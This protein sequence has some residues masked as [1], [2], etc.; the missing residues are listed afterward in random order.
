VLVGRDAEFGALRDAVV[1]AMGGR[2]CAVC[3]EGEPGIGKTALVEA[4][5]AGI[6]QDHPAVQVVSAIGVESEFSLA[7]AGLL[8]LLTPMLDRLDAL[9]TGQRLALE[10]AFG[11]SESPEGADRFLVAVATL[12]LLSLHADERP[13]IL[14]LDDLQWIDPETTAALNFSARRIGH[15]RIAM[16]LT[17][18]TLPGTENERQ[19]GVRLIPLAG[20]PA[21]DAGELLAGTVAQILVE[22]LVRRTGGNPLALLELTRSLSPAQRRGSVPLPTAL[23]VG[24]RLSEAFA[25]S[26]AKLS[27]AARRLVTLTAA[28]IDAE[29]GPLLRAMDDEGI[30]RVSAVAQAESSGVLTFHT[31]GVR[32]RHPLL[33]NA[34][35]L[36][37]TE[38]ERRSAHSSLASAYQHRPGIRLRHLAE[39]STGPDDELGAAL[40]TLAD[41]E[42]TRSGFAAA[43]VIAERASVL[44]S[45]SGP[46][47]DALAGAVEDAALSGDVERV[48]TLVDRIGVEPVDVSPQA[49]AR[50]LLCAGTLEGNSGSVTRAAQLLTRAAEIGTGI[51]RVRSLVELLHAHY[52]LGSVEGMALAAAAIEVNADPGE[53]EQAM[54]VAYSAASA[55]A[56]AGDGPAAAGPAMRA[57][58]LLDRTPGLL[59]DPRHLIVAGLASSWAGTLQLAYGDAPRRLQTARS[60]GAIGVLPTVLTLLAG[61]ATVFGR[62]QDAFAYAG[63]AVELGTE[64]GFVVDVST[65]QEILAWELAA[66]DYPEQA[67]QALR[68][69]RLLHDRAGVSAA[70]VH[71]ELVEAF[72]A[73]CAGNL[74]RVV[75]ILEDR[76]AVDGGR[77][78]SGN[79]PMSVA[80]DLV[81]AYLGL[82]R[83]DDADDITAR[84]AELHRDS[85][86]PDIRGEVLRLAGMTT[87]NL[88][89]AMTFFEA[90]HLAHTAG[91]DTFSA[92]RTR[93]LHG[94][95][96]RRAGERRAA[97]EQLRLAAEAFRLMGLTLWVRR[98]EAE[99]AATGSTARRG[100][101]RD[102][103]L[104]S[105]ETRV[106]LFVAKGLTNREIAAALFLSPRTVEHHVTSVLRKRGLNSRV[107]LAAEFAS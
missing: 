66:R 40:L 35:W 25:Q 18:R 4:V 45:G 69:A 75:D 68:D 73:L 47:L 43:S 102:A 94:Q 82:H 71:V 53:P 46:S 57:V 48:R 52:R 60:Q 26:I 41:S 33:R 32:F 79:Y 70:A 20:L 65:A 5:V 29:T 21:R 15:D 92:A 11:R 49:H 10:R 24:G 74:Q 30:D 78:P 104:T 23:P 77:Q 22:P 81:E 8:D 83:P 62:H 38:T 12:A 14:L 72:C 56:F 61:G 37:A 3:V 13:L 34:A 54:L 16:L 101:Q 50:A 19:P 98:A 96:L 9:P 105:Q 31:D 80:P 6:R 106:A 100:P 2:G 55:L 103:A 91:Y 99:L 44:L 51:T 88:P 63:E 90:A 58:E 95:R 107:E 42:R 89:E 36:A 86:D 97:R 39:A 7:H 85:P 1:G 17:R 93:L 84:H 27:P 87:Q 64:L 59:D 76:I 67:A 28:S